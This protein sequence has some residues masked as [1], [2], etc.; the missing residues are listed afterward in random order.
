VIQ[1]RTLVDHGQE[2]VEIARLLASFLERAERTLDIA[3]Y[4]VNLRDET[5]NVVL[6]TLRVAS[7]RGVRV[8]LLYNVDRRPPG[9]VAPPPPETRPE[10]IEALPFETVGVPGWP[11]LMHHKYVVRDGASVWTGSTNWT[12]DSWSREENVIAVVDS[13]AV[14]G[15]YSED[16]EQ[17]RR[18]QEVRR[19]GRVSSEP[20]DGIRV[21]FSP[22]RGGRLAH[23]IAHAIGRA[24]R[25]VRIAS[26]VITSGPILGTLAEAIADGE[27]DIAGV[28]DN[29]QIN[30]VLRQWAAN[31]IQT[32]KAPA[33]RTALTA[34]PFSGKRTTP[35]APG[36]VHDYMHAKVTVCDDVLFVGSFNLSHSGES[37]AENVLEIKNAALAGQLAAYVDEV[38]ARYPAVE[39]R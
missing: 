24:E 25:R 6:D 39:L 15:R 33:L 32:W 11:D 17:L 2:P 13:A 28:V 34:A 27:V 36:S 14:A 30:E 10:E 12:D 7:R 20:A 26:P 8:R 4:D 35:Y 5:E 3:I 29:T 37:N 22:K 38:R 31:S 1:L 21:W 9:E 18:R 19:S 16:F 23:R